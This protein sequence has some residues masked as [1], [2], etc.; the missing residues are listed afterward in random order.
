MSRP[1]LPIAVRFTKLLREMSFGSLS[2]SKGGLLLI[3]IY[4]D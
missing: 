2:V 4:Y 1:A 3:T